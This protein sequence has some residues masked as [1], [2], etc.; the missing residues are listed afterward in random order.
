MSERYLGGNFYFEQKESSQEFSKEESDD[1][2][3]S[4]LTDVDISNPSD[5]QTLVYNATAQ[6]WENGEGG[7]ATPKQANTT[8]SANGSVSVNFGTAAASVIRFAVLIATTGISNL[9]DKTSL[10]L[11]TGHGRSAA[12]RLVTPIVEGSG[13]TITGTDAGFTISSS[14]TVYCSFTTL[15]DISN[16]IQFA[17]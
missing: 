17:S 8:I 6:K 1:S 4:G 15:I 3:L 2:T 11:V 13:I 10:Y 16:A 5:G 12:A 14:Y 9:S 7:G